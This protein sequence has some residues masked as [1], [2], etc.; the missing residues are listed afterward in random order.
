M[1]RI[2]RAIL[3]GAEQIARGYE[4]VGIEQFNLHL[5]VGRLIESVYSRL[6]DMRRKRRAR[7]GLETPADR[8]PGMDCRRSKRQGAGPNRGGSAFL[9]EGT[10]GFRHT[11]LFILHEPSD[12]QMPR[13]GVLLHRRHGDLRGVSTLKKIRGQW[14]EGGGEKGGEVTF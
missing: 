14:M 7:V 11:M 6:D 4:L 3:H 13:P 9:Q 5:A 1:H 8:R 2:D 12:L 10:S